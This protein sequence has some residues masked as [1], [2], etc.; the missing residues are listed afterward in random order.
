MK[1]HKKSL[2][3][4]RILTGDMAEILPVGLREVHPGDTFQGATSILLRVSPLNA[5]VMHPVRV[6]IEHYFVPH[7]LVWEDFE[8]FITGGEDGLNASVF[9]TV[10]LDSTEAAIGTLADYL[11]VPVPGGSPLS[12]SALPF[13]GYAMIYNEFKRNT[14]L[15][16]AIAVSV[17][18]GVDATTSLD[19]KKANWMKDRFTDLSPEPQLGPDVTISLGTTAPVEYVPGATNA[20]KMIWRNA[21][22][23][24][25]IVSQAQYSDGSGFAVSLSGVGEIL[26]PNDRLYVD[27]SAATGIS[28][29]TLRENT[30]LQ[31]YMENRMMNGSR[32]SD[33][34]RSLGV[35]YSDARLQRPEKLGSN[36]STVQFSEV[37][38][39]G[40]TTAGATAGVGNLK[41]HGIG[42]A[43]GN[44][45]RKSFEEHG[46][47]FT[48]CTVLPTTMY[49]Q[50]IPRHML[51]R[52]KTDFWTPEF[53]H[54]GQQEVTKKEIYCQAADPDEV[55][56]Y[57]NRYR[58]YEEEPSTVHGEFK[59]T[60]DFWHYARLFASEP[61]LNS[62][63]V[64]AD[65][66][67][68]VNQVTSA[69]VLWIFAHNSLQARR[70]MGDSRPGGTL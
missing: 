16:T 6:L 51:R 39:T 53:A 17:A 1:R 64:T 42:T 2:S 34:L 15:Q 68:R 8:D 19:L 55:M 22:T 5:P 7:R 3:N 31:R 32:F 43:R 56:G 14:L 25:A 67:K 66:T 50:G 49:A 65:P 11:G 70:L 40:V 29:R 41:G 4:Y 30:A 36:V 13:R 45:Y 12:I 47:V 38:Q 59:S 10:S 52:S 58:E 46:Y 62:A 54:V 27:L 60:L 21:S 24:A 63:F 44:R 48:L 20:N 61:A 69:D 23:D 28:I 33:L 26:D 35:R 37:L 57:E 9:P 18:S